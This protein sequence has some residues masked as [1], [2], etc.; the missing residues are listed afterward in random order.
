MTLRSA[1]G[2]MPLL[3]VLAAAVVV[4]WLLWPSV[5]ARLQAGRGGDGVPPAGVSPALAEATLDRV[6]NLRSDSAGQTLA[7]GDAEL[8]SVVRYAMPGLLPPGVIDPEVQVR[9]GEVA[10]SARIAR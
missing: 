6:E 1:L 7:L 9:E 10:L 8:S 4:G 3:V 5:S 2:R